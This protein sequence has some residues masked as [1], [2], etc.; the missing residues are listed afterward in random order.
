MKKPKVLVCLADFPFP[1][2]KNGYSIRYFPILQHFSRLY[3]MDLFVSVGEVAVPEEEKAQ[4]EQFFSR[5]TFYK[6]KKVHK[7]SMYKGMRRLISLIPFTTPFDMINY[8]QESLDKLFQEHCAGQHYVLTVCVSLT[9]FTVAKKYLPGSRITLDV[10]D[11][12]NSLKKRSAASVI[13][14]YEVMGT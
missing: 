4:A 1:A 5:I 9:L 14:H 2:R 13:E 8:D 11:S 7:G 6:K 10:I 12:A 3:D